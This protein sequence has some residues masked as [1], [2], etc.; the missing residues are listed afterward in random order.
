MF[1]ITLVSAFMVTSSLL[2]L[3]WVDI[4][5]L[6]NSLVWMMD[7][8]VTSKR[9]LCLLPPMLE[10]VQF[11]PLKPTEPPASRPSKMFSILKTLTAMAKSLDVKML[12]CNVLSV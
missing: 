11:L 7:L 5:S 8:H 6:T 4:I 9:M 10:S 2:L 12:L 1:N 3:L